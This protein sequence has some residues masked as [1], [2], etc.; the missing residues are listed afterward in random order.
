MR[1]KLIVLLYNRVHKGSELKGKKVNT[2]FS[3][4]KERR[5][6]TKY[7]QLDK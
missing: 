1:E 5:I 2:L 6:E 7:L 3:K 4:R